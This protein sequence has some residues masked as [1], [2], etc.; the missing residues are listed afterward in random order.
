MAVKP[1][2][3][4]TPEQ[5]LDVQT[6][7]KAPDPEGVALAELMA[8]RKRIEAAKVT[9]PPNPRPHCSDCAGAFVRGWRAALEVVEGK[10]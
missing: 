6:R 7:E 3:L 4:R 1:H 9:T 2:E 8:V 10:G 5:G